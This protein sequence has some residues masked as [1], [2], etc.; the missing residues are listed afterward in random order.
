MLRLTLVAPYIVELI[1]GGRHGPEV[2]LAR[3]QEPFPVEWAAQTGSIAAAH[4]R[5]NSQNVGIG[6][7]NRW[8]SSL[9]LP[10][11]STRKQPG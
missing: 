10:N 1:L 9:V 11:V 5:C 8:T 2:T 4:R 3:L 6:S 7:T